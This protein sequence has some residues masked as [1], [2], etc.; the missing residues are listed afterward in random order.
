MPERVLVFCKTPVAGITPAMLVAELRDADLMTLAECLDLPEGESAAVKTMWKHFRLEHADAKDLDGVEL[1]WH[2]KHRPIQ[3]RRGPPLGG[4]LAELLEG[5]EGVKSKGAARV[6]KHLKET[7][8]VAEFEMGIP[9]SLDLAAT[10]SEVL[11]FFV[12][13]RGDGIVL[14]YNRE[15][16]SPENRGATLLK[17]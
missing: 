15:F 10:I 8:E 6:R 16:A 1:H 17:R 4:E 2:E 11:A 3:V 12:A 7:L 9:G 14:F 5:L 13:E